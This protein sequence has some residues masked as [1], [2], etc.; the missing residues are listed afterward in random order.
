MGYANPFEQYGL[1]KLMQ[2]CVDVG[3]HGFV[4][5][6]LPLEESYKF[7]LKCDEYK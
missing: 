1:D 3:V 6:D 5:V 7:R 2:K 4:N